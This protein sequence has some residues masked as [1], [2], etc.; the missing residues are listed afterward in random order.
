MRQSQAFYSK[1]QTNSRGTL[2]GALSTGFFGQ[3]IKRNNE[4]GR[5]LTI[6]FGIPVL[7]TRGKTDVT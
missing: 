5:D 6:N 2:P 1:V 3:A 7:P 4:A